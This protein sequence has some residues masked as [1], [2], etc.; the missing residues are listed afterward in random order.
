[1]PG[2]DHEPEEEEIAAQI[3]AA[4]LAEYEQAISDLAS[5][6]LLLAEEHRVPEQARDELRALVEQAEPGQ[7]A[8][9][10]DDEQQQHER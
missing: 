10:H 7:R 2:H 9:R 3:T 5:R 1:M 8:A 6:L 4:L